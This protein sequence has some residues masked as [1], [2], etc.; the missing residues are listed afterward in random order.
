[1]NKGLNSAM[2][3]LTGVV[4]IA[5]VALGIA[6]ATTN[7]TERVQ[8]GLLVVAGLLILGGLVAVGRGARGARGVVA[9]GTILPALMTVW[10]II[11]PLIAIGICVWLLLSA[12]AGAPRPLP[13]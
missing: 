9:V 1:M 3:A 7:D 12:R 5:T 13:G 2:I 8:G 10:T 6:A 4:G 11:T